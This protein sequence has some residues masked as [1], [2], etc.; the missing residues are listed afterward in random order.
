MWKNWPLS[1][2]RGRRFYLSVFAFITTN[3]IFGQDFLNFQSFEHLPTFPSASLH[4]I[5]QDEYGFI[6]LATA[7]GLVKFDGSRFETA[8][9]SL[10]DGRK[11]PTEA[12]FNV[13]SDSKNQIWGGTFSGGLYRVD[14]SINKAFHYSSSKD[15]I[16]T[17]TDDRIKRVYEDPEGRIWVGCHKEGF[18]LY[19]P[20]TDDFKCYKPSDILN[21]R[22][23]ER[24][25]DDILSFHFQ[26]GA[27]WVGTLNGVLRFEPKT[28]ELEYID[29]LEILQNPKTV[30]GSAN[31]VREICPIN[32]NEFMFLPYSSDPVA[33]IYNISK[34]EVR[35]IRLISNNKAIARSAYSIF[36]DGNEILYTEESK[37]AKINTTDWSVTWTDTSA[38]FHNKPI[39]F[40][41][42]FNDKKGNK[43]GISKREL[44]LFRSQKFP[45][46]TIN[47]PF[48]SESLFEL[49][50]ENILF[51]G[52]GSPTAGVYNLNNKNIHLFNYQLGGVPKNNV[53]IK[54]VFRSNDGHIY[55]HSNDQ[56]YE[57]NSTTGNFSTRWSFPDYFSAT[58]FESIISGYLD[59]ND[60]YWFGTKNSGILRVDLIENKIY[61]YKNDP[62][63]NSSTIVYNGYP[64]GFFHD[65]ENRIWYGTDVGFGYFDHKKNEFV[66]FPFS[67][68]K[69]NDPAFP[70]KGISLIKKDKKGRIWVA[71]NH[72]GFGYFDIQKKTIKTFSEKDGLWDCHI[73]DMIVDKAGDIWISHWKGISRINALDLRV[74]NFGPESGFSENSNLFL[75]ED[76]SIGVFKFGQV[77]KIWPEKI[78]E[79]DVKP[80]VTLHDFKVFDK[81]LNLE[82]NWNEVEKINLTYEQDFFSIYFGAINFQNPSVQEIQYR[83]DGL[84]DEWINTEDRNYVSFANVGGGDYT[85]KFRARLKSRKWGEVKKL[86][87]SI[88]YPF[89]ETWWFYLLALSSITG[90]IYAFYDYRIKKITEKEE[91]KSQF[92]VQLAEVEMTA[93]RAQMNPHFLFNCLN[94]IKLFFVENNVE[95]A[96]EY[97]TKFSKLIRLILQN[98]NTKLVCLADEI[99]ALNLYI[100]MEKMRFDNQFEYSINIAP[101]IDTQHLEIP[102]LLL[103]PY[104]EN[105]IWHGLVH[106]NQPNRLQIS[107]EKQNG[108]LTCTIE[109]NGIGREA[110]RKRNRG[111]EPRKKSLGM[112]ITQDRINLI[113]RL[114]KVETKVSVI[115]LKNEDGSSGGTKVIITMPLQIQQD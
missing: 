23:L 92:Q 2:F 10:G 7:E 113:Q 26:A 61:E 35:A 14:L 25:L 46:S 9:T 60:N 106:T 41:Y 18:C 101:V 90:I 50:N 55:G 19:R 73:R 62:I 16:N 56:I 11:L 88:A 86:K 20:K 64:K 32:E 68:Y 107:V 58:S 45:E 33:F 43:W 100:E 13:F 44:Y 98:S 67:E 81:T 22:D 29:Y 77:Q 8:K 24:F 17:I 115:D 97:L 72:H 110:A 94:S 34:K 99:E 70:M 91:L 76:G 38:Q 57:Y 53:D 36:K 40:R 42:L 30:K 95:S 6:W 59:S 49:D 21:K 54:K 12:F 66:N 85:F 84:H 112:E 109:D 83:L 28:E 74:E 89:W 15:Q 96:T 102:P 4:D 48:I 71:E 69:T 47:L 111:R 80:Q 93:L 3:F 37:V 103:Q 31:G 63:L 79:I 105:A 52:D 82:K 65:D 75:F 39:N 108:Y 27:L 87:I 104:V 51:L 1:T 78:A 114:Y 5:A